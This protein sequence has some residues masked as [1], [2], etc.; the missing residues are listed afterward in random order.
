MTIL[1]FMSDSPFLTF[2]I[3]FIVACAIVEI[4]KWIAYAI[5]GGKPPEDDDDDEQGE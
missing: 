5:R 3:V 2:F 1:Q 4:V